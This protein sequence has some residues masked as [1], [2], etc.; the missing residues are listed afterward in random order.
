MRPHVPLYVLGFCLERSWRIGH[1]RRERAIRDG[2]LQ[3]LEL[4][5]EVFVL[6]VDHGLARR[7]GA[8]LSEYEEAVIPL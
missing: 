1:E 5:G 7:I 8:A 4:P 2:I 6:C 3:S